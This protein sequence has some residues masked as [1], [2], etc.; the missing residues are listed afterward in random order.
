[1]AICNSRRVATEEANPANPLISGSTLQNCEKINFC[2]LSHPV[3]STSLGMWKSN[4]TL[5][6]PIDYTFHEV[7]QDRILEWVAFPVSRGPSQLRDWTQVS[8]YCRQI[9]YQMSH[10]GSPRILEWVAYHFSSRSSQ[11]RNQTRVSCIA[12]RFL[13]HWAM[14]EASTLLWWQAN[15]VPLPECFINSRICFLC[16]VTFLCQRNEH[17][18]WDDHTW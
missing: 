11:P 13:I 2:C 14:R 18:S 12:G 10:K 6:D 16:S 8:L 1:M 7:L 9:L 17:C 3:S 4:L 5:C 15:T